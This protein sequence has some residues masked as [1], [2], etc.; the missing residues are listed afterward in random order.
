MSDKNIET[1]LDDIISQYSLVEY[2]IKIL[3][4]VVSNINQ[5]LNKHIASYNE[6][7]QRDND[8]AS[9]VSEQLSLF[10]EMMNSIGNPSETIGGF[11]GG[12]N[13]VNKMI[14]E[15]KKRM[16]EIRNISLKNIDND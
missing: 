12:I 16:Q 1:K 5:N 6:D 13:D 9:K 8:A 7:R 15:A 11:E 3:M 14:S 2:H 4:E 10:P